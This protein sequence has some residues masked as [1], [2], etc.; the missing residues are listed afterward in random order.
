MTFSDSFSIVVLANA[1]RNYALLCTVRIFDDPKLVRH[2]IVESLMK[3]SNGSDRAGVGQGTLTMQLINGT[4]NFDSMRLGLK[5]QRA[6]SSLKPGATSTLSMSWGVC[7]V[8]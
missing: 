6:G 5:G 2:L 4:L 1:S 3:Q 7:C 8:L